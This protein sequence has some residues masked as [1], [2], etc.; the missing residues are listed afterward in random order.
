MKKLLELR[1]QKAELHQ[2]MKT[3]VETAENEKRSLTSDENEKFK[4][5]QI[6][7]QDVNSNIERAETLADQ[8]RSIFTGTTHTKKDDKPN[9]EELRTFVRTGENRSLSAGIAAD[10][11]FTVI[12][13]VSRDIYVLLGDNSVF[14]QNALVQSISTEIYKKLVSAGGTTS[15]WAGEGDERTE[16]D[17]SKLKEI[18]ISLHSLYAYPTTTQELL[19]W[20][21]F[22]IAGWITSEVS[23]NSVEK[24][25]AAF[26]N[27]DAVKKP[28]GILTYPKATTGDATRAFGT[29]QEIE[30]A[31]ADVIDFDDLKDFTKTLRRGYR[32]AAKFYMNDDTQ[33][34]LGKLKNN[35]GDYILQDSVTEGQPNTLLGKPVEIDEQLADDYIAYG[36]LTRAYTVIDHTSG[37]RMLRDNVTQPGFV[38]MFTTRYVGGG[39]LDS[40]AIKFLK[41]KAA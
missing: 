18:Q 8:E 14:R 22:D 30:S 26:W 9:N 21:D 17:T 34:K 10:G 27:G 13:S 11:G 28:K 25:N 15:Q 35:Q 36:D 5:L 39:L 2:Q 23:L 3:L 32:D 20:S 4:A 37:V 41:A 38:K 31:V 33:T 24:E 7:I 40:N 1:N 29:I 16:T 19:D 6:N 12:P